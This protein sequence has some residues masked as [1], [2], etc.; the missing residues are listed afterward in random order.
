MTDQVR[1]EPS[2]HRF[3]IG[4]GDALAT[5]TYREEADRIVFVHTGVPAELEGGGIG[6]QLA[7]AGLKYAREH[8][9]LVVP[10]CPFVAAYI[11]RNPEFAELVD[12]DYR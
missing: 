7:Q 8:H 5:L 4:E 9:L 2:R 10:R 6:A 3:A 12:P 1:H 11:K